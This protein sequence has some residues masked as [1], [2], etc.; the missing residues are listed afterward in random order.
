MN[1]LSIILGVLLLGSLWGNA[2]QAWFYGGFI[3][4]WREASLEALELRGQVDRLGLEVSV[5][6]AQLEAERQKPPREIISIRTV[7]VDRPVYIDRPV[8]VRDTAWRPPYWFASYHL[9]KVAHGN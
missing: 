1:K 7:E 8:I 5:L 6:K 2:C 4:A 9:W 3:T